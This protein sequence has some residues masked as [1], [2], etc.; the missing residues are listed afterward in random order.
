MSTLGPRTWK[1]TPLR[2]GSVSKLFHWVIVALIITQ[3]VLAN[4]AEDLPLGM[5][6]LATL[7]R[8]KSV[9][10]TILALAV[11]RLLWRLYNRN[12]PPLP[13]DL[14]P[15]QRGL[16]HLTHY[17]LYLLLFAMPLSGW[18]MSSAKNYPV[19]WFGMFTLPN[20][21]PPDEGVFALMKSTHG[22]LAGT[23]VVIATLHVLA[24]LYHHFMKKDDVLRRMLP[25][26]MLPFM[27]LGASALPLA[28]AP[29]PTRA[30]EP[31]VS[32]W[33]ADPAG[34]TLEFQF[35]QAG[36]KTMGRFA[37]FTADI[38]FAAATPAAGKFDVAIDMA[39][40]DTRDKERDDTL[41]MP[42]LFSIAK[43]PRATYVA[44]QFVAK[45]GGFEGK[46][47]LTLRGIA[48]DVPVTFTFVPSTDAGKPVA[49]LKGT[50][51]V[52]RLLFGV[53]QGEWK[54]TEWISDDVLV[55]FSLLLRPR[56]ARPAIP[57]TP[58]PA[59]SK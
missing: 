3:F 46:G 39:S 13:A 16:A 52:K 54:S 4:M 59:Q 40:A 1:N 20:L 45:G 43:F 23:L 53:G 49:T 42:D 31:A 30:A 57:A 58:T 5:A 24:A 33:A 47:K 21:V 14:K 29:L 26:A 8:H 48:L 6:K 41:R 27:M 55:Q 17:G 2:W 25:F 22:V 34:S 36:A 51:T 7:A 32:S 56:A 50:A 15:Y 38:D 9:G 19:S 11:L 12:S 35:V 18:M 28:A 44:G 37:R 10:I